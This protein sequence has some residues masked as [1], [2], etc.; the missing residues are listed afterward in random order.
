MPNAYREGH[1]KP[2]SSEQP[3]SREIASQQARIGAGSEED[4]RRSCSRA[5]R[6]ASA[7][8]DDPILW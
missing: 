1:L 7:R 4:Q 2:S 3:A 5:K 6:V 8:V